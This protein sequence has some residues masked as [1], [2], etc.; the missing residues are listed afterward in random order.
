MVTSKKTVK[1]RLGFVLNRNREAS[2]EDSAPIEG[3]LSVWGFNR[4]IRRFV[5][6][7]SGCG[8]VEEALDV[9]NIFGRRK[10]KEMAF[11]QGY[12][13]HKG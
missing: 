10:E 13:N 8:D 2:L 6:A 5:V 1:V 4:E 7:T 11:F 12:T 9:G 3:F